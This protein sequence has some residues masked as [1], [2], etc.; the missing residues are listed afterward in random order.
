MAKKTLATLALL[1]T[2]G[3]FGCGKAEYYNFSEQGIVCNTKYT[4]E[5]KE[6]SLNPVIIP[7]G[8]SGLGMTPTG[9]I[10]IRGMVA[11]HEEIIP[12]E[13]EV[14][15][16][17]DNHNFTVK[18]EAGKSLYSKLEKGEKVIVDCQKKYLVKYRDLDKDGEKEAVK[19][20][21]IYVKLLDANP[22]KSQEKR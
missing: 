17:T 22:I 18:D 8:E 16:N 14:T 19:R 13:Y 20:K 6:S 21:L 12:A 4:P 15:I 7:L 2:I 1:G 10:G 3:L 9:E 5:R 11:D